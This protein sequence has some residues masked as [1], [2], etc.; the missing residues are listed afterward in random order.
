MSI[1]ARALLVLALLL[2]LGWLAAANLASPELRQQSLWLPDQGLRLGLDLRGGVHL[3][4]GPDLESAV[5]HELGVLATDLSA[6]LERKGI[7][8]LKPV[9]VGQTLRVQTGSREQAEALRE[10]LDDYPV[11][12]L[13]E[14]AKAEGAAFQMVLADEQVRFVRERAIQ[15]VLEVLRRRIDDPTTG[16]SESVI[17]KQG[18]ERVLVQI[19]GVE[20]VPTELITGKG[21]LEFKIVEDQAANEE[22][23]RERHPEGLP[24]GMVIATEVD[25]ATGSVIAAYLLPETPALTGDLLAD[26][27]SQFNQQIGQWR[28]NFRWNSEGADRFADLTGRNINRQLAILLDGQVQSAPAIRSKIYERGEISGDFTQ[29]EAAELAVIL[30]AGSLPIDIRIEEERTIGPAL[31]QDSIDRGLRASLIG[32]LLIVVFISAYYRLSGLYASLA[33]VANL[34]MLLGLMSVFGATLTLPGIAGLVLTVGMAVDAN[35]IIFERI[36]EELR[37]GRAVQAA[38]ATGFQKARW[39]ILDANITTLL[40]AIILFEAGTGPIKGFA[41]TLSVGILTSVFSALVIT[42]LLYEWRPGRVA[43]RALSI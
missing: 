24:E 17:T 26:A 34:T 15:Q 27:A 4:L 22:L 25:A 1:R 19:P 16:I 28:I 3:V 12:E 36:R 20:R 2:C 42:R 30:R 7:L 10:I 9:V 31:G 18:R 37:A 8:E 21:Y 6:E 14:S 35:V 33:L 38:I 40:T 11:A 41:V 29:Q 23:L 43:T 5:V 32:L 13:R 39:T